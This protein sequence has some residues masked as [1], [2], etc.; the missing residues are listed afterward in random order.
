MTFELIK[1]EFY[2]RIIIY[3]VLDYVSI[4]LKLNENTRPLGLWFEEVF[5]ALRKLPRFLIPTYFDVVVTSV[6]NILLSKCAFHMSK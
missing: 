1:F 5:E 2:N 3:N 4:R 6:T